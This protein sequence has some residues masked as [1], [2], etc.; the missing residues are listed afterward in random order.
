M[1]KEEKETFEV[2]ICETL[3]KIVKVPARNKTEA[4]LKVEDD[5]NNAKHVLSSDDYSTTEFRIL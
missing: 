4:L 2:E 1:D 5:Y 3:V